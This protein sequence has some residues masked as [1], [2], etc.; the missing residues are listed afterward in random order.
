MICVNTIDF[1]D[2]DANAI[3]RGEL[4]ATAKNTSFIALFG[5][6]A[7]DIAGNEVVAI[8]NGGAQQAFAYNQD[9]TNPEVI[10][11]SLDMNAEEL[12]FTF[13]ETVDVSSFTPQQ[14]RFQ[15]SNSR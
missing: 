10:G 12:Q 14:L 6:A 2:F 15:D 4:S 5:P 3:K 11:F 13:S 7:K 8:L 9:T 1:T